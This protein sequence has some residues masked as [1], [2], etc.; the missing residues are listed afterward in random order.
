MKKSLLFA[1]VVL[2]GIQFI[3]V[4]QTNPPVESDFMESYAVKEI[5]KKACYDCHSNE[6][7]WKWYTKIS[8]LSWLISK[9][10]NVGREHLNFSDWGRMETMKKKRARQEI[11][12]EIQEEK[13][14]LWQYRV[15]HSESKLSPEEKVSIRAWA[16]NQ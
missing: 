8:P 11:W 5:F 10:V 15:L 6:T 7:D 13:M 14:P 16:L 12:E 3:P 2:V 1:L 4:E 9:D